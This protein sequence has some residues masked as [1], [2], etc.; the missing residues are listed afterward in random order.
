MLNVEFYWKDQIIH[1]KIKGFKTGSGSVNQKTRRLQLPHYHIQ[2]GDLP[3]A[4]SSQGC[5]PLIVDE[6]IGCGYPGPG[7]ALKNCM[8]LSE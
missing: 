6:V 7:A 5:S 8:A 4:L 3:Q 2:Q 1:K